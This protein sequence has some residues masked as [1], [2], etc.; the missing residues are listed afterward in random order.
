MNGWDIHDSS[1]PTAQA[2]PAKW[3]TRCGR[4]DVPVEHTMTPTPDSHYSV[5]CAE[6]L[7]VSS[8]ASARQQTRCSRVT[9][10]TSRAAYACGTRACTAAAWLTAALPGAKGRG[11]EQPQKTRPEN[12][13]GPASEHWTGRD[14]S[15]DRSVAERT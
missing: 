1:S 10:W 15:P 9:R 5:T 13:L 11:G 3:Q 14:M 7:H 8:A 6:C 12:G 2:R 4:T